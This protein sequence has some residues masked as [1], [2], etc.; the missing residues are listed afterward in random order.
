M[1]GVLTGMVAGALGAVNLPATIDDA[2]NESG[3]SQITLEGDG[4]WTTAG[5]GSSGEW[6]TPSETAIAALYEA[7]AS[8][9]AGD[10]G[11]AIGTFD[12]WLDLSGGA[13]WGVNGT[14]KLVTFTLE[15]R[16]K[17]THTVRDSAACSCGTAS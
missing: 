7:R 8:S 17:A 10:V 11:D 16:D 13:A 6:V 2:I 1:S 9:L 12:T 15:I 4:D 5:G 3:I 14:N